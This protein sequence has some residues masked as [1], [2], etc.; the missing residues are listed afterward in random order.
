MNYTVVKQ[1]YNNAIDNFYTFFYKIVDFGKVLFELFFAFY[2]IWEAFFL[3]FIN[4]FMYIYH[5]ILFIIDKSTESRWSIF[6]WRRIPKRSAYRPSRAYTADSY[7]PI[8]AQYGKAAITA[9]SAAT[10]ATVRAVSEGARKIRSTPSGARVSPLK[11]ISE[12]FGSIASGI[13]KAVLWPFRTIGLFFSGRMKPVKEAPASG[14]SLIDE[15]M[16]EYE[17][18]RGR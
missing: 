16:K 5:T 4:I 6:F 3:I 1:F 9:A 15:Y 11:K 8:P 10:S 18:R 12:I 17:Q 2:E 7:N 13:G 14:K